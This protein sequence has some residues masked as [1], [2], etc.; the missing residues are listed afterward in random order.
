MARRKRGRDVHGWL[1]VDKPVGPT[2]SDV[3]TMCRRALDARKAGHAGTL[4][5]LASGL[6]AVAFGEATKTVP[7]VQDGAKAYRFTA[8][9]GQATST[10]DGEGEVI[11][12]SASRPSDDEIRAALAPFTGAIMQVPP[13][14]SAVK[15]SGRRAYDLARA[16][17]ED[18]GAMPELAP[19]P[20]TVH[21]L[22]LVDRPDAD[23]A[24]LEMT[25]GKGGYVRSI[26]RDL[27]RALGC[28]AHVSALRRLSSG[29]LTLDGAISFAPGEKIG[30]EAASA[31]LRPVAT[32]L[33]DIPA[34]AV[35]GEDADRIRRGMAHASAGF[36]PDWAEGA[37]GWAAEERGDERVPVAIG[38]RAGHFFRP[39]R[40][41]N[42]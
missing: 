35:S 3:V 22:A 23:H 41:F 38:A 39:T 18:P 1:I 2:S 40:V 32:G 27:G 20:L 31:H 42:L 12:E 5:P 19:R 33:D 8:R 29:A 34:L 37:T 24:V 9:L 6:L 16:A 25:C 15:V 28:H 4:D 10:D 21:A 30:H 17:A 7:L 26:A 13:V 36:P 11:A 14:F